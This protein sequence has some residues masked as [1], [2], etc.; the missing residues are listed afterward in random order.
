ML[1]EFSITHLGNAQLNIKFS[2]FHLIEKWNKNIWNFY[3]LLI[4]N[5]NSENTMTIKSSFSIEN[6]L[7]KPHKN[8]ATN[9]H[10]KSESVNECS[11]NS[12]SDG[13]TS[14][15]CNDLVLK[16]EPNNGLN[17]DSDAKDDLADS[18]RTNFTSPD[19]SG[20]EEE[21]ADNLSDITTGENG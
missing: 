1:T 10:G 17:C 19:S 21:N 6:I 9:C 12:I 15:I 5:M 20:C 4:A 18:I 2:V 16:K 14:L 11:E 3:H 7:S 8:Q 13:V